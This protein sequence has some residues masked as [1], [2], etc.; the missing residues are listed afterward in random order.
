LLHLILA[1]AFAGELLVITGEVT[2][3]SEKAVILSTKDL[4]YFIKRSAL[5]PEQQRELLKKIN[6]TVDVAVAPEAVTRI[7][8]NEKKE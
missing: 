2:S 8:R 1:A 4:N 5:T 3:V 7:R 6:Q